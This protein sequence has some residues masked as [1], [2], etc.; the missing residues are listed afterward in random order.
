MRDCKDRPAPCNEINLMVK[1]YKKAGFSD[2]GGGVVIFME[3]D[4]EML[5]LDYESVETNVESQRNLVL[6]ENNSDNP[7]DD[8]DEFNFE[9]LMIDLQSVIAMDE[10]ELLAYQ[11]WVE[12]RI[13]D[14]EERIFRHIQE[15]NL[16]PRDR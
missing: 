13:A 15:K 6:L 9:G 11:E 14:I 2:G 4:V 10:R 8:E 16:V 5:K 1:Y 12:L 7:E 3:N